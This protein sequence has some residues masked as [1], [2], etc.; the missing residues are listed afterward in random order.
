[1]RTCFSGTPFS[2]SASAI[3]SRVSPISDGLPDIRSGRG[4][5]GALRGAITASETDI[6]YPIDTS[7]LSA[8]KARGRACLSVKSGL[9]RK[10]IQAPDHDCSGLYH[11][12]TATS[13]YLGTYAKRPVS[14]RPLSDERKADAYLQV[15][16]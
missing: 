7:P 10:A 15:S 1:M 16:I 11:Q 12:I 5:S 9:D 13:L 8:L 3:I 2:F 6:L 14:D 4:T